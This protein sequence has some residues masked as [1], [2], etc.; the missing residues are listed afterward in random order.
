MG[1]KTH[2]VPVELFDP[3]TGRSIVVYQRELPLA[4]PESRAVMVPPQ[5]RE[6]VVVRPQRRA[7]TRKRK[8]R[9]AERP[10]TKRA[11]TAALCFL[12]FILSWIPCGLDCPGGT[13]LL[14]GV[15]ASYILYKLVR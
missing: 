15:L 3:V 6:V 11:T 13:L 4:E 12:V 8:R 9:S 14:W 5:R 7:M 1:R 2:L 10:R